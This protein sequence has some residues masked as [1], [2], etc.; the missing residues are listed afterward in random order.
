MQ[1]A[2]TSGNIAG[3]PLASNDV[4]FVPIS[5]RNLRISVE[6]CPVSSQVSRP[7]SEWYS[8]KLTKD[9]ISTGFFFPLGKGVCLSN[10]MK[11]GNGECINKL[12]KCD[13][14]INCPDGSDENDCGKIFNGF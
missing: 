11:C 13:G 4:S 3:V 14:E 5:G 6:S 9:G 7:L 12:W 8:S 1:P 10:E 2:V